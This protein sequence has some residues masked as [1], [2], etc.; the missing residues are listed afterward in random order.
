MTLF[1][2]QETMKQPLHVERARKNAANELLSR[3]G[4]RDDPVG[5]TYGAAF[6]TN[7]RIV[8][9]LRVPEHRRGRSV[10]D[11]QGR[12]AAA[13]YDDAKALG[14]NGMAQWRE[15]AAR[16]RA[17]IAQPL[18]LRRRRGP[19]RRSTTEGLN[20]VVCRNRHG[21]AATR[22]CSPP[23][24]FRLWWPRVNAP[25]RWARRCGA[26][27]IE[28]EAE[29]ERSLLAAITPAT[30][31][32]AASHVHWATGTRLDLS[33]VSA[34]LCDA[35][36]AFCLV[37]GV[38]ALGAVPVDLGD[39]RRVLRVRL[40]VAAVRVRAGRAGR[41]RSAHATVDRPPCEGTT[42]R[43]RR[44]SCSTR[45]STIRALFALAATLEY[46]ETTIG[47]PS[48][49]ASVESL[50]GQVTNGLV[51]RGLTVVTPPGARAGIVGC[52]VPNPDGVRDALAARNVFVESR[53]GL[54]RV[55]PHF[56]NTTAD[57]RAFV[58]A[59]AGV[60]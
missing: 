44:R 25:S 29:R 23:T 35:V 58:D 41:P 37:D 8:S 52:R 19:F 36:G 47:W 27:E 30:R 15:P 7:F 40:Q 28:S 20:L 6:A 16:A 13:F 14:Y 39:D 43:R 12:A 24:N 31:M 26:C 55:S 33:R 42:I 49:F 56:Y 11:G 54:L 53:E 1:A 21:G 51:Q 18:R 48:V 57:V 38:Q 17:S 9:R 46:L 2:G 32:L 60:V 3:D 59:L 5:E 4:D 22:S 45:T 50:A 34:A 10:V